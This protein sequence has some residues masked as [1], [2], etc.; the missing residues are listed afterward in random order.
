[1]LRL[2][3][4]RFSCA[5]ICS[6]KL[7]S[8]SRSATHIDF[9]GPGDASHAMYAILYFVGILA[10]TARHV[11]RTH[12]LIGALPAKVCASSFDD[13]SARHNRKD[14]PMKWWMWYWL[15]ITVLS[16]MLNGLPGAFMSSLFF[17]LVMY[18]PIWLV[19]RTVRATRKATRK[20]TPY[21]IEMERVVDGPTDI[22]ESVAD[23]LAAYEELRRSSLDSTEQPGEPENG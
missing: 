7:T 3:G 21:I 2:L 4:T 20:A 19:M 13:D 5:M 16:L 17:G 8:N 9:A 6:V 22:N 1:M 12:C 14:T 10:S 11:K 18:V 23:G 15:V